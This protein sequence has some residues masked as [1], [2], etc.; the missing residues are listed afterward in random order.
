MA[1]RPSYI[2]DEELLAYREERLRV[3]DLAR[4][5]QALR[6]SR[7]LRERLAQL[8]EEEDR[9]WYSVGAVWRAHRISCPDRDTLAAYCC[10]ALPQNEADYIRFHIDV[11]GCRLCEAELTDAQR[12]QQAEEEARATPRRKRLYESSLRYLP[13]DR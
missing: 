6:E 2:S 7:Q 13:S 8:V 5:E 4:I 11:V 3:E 10:G 1:H 9:G 12:R